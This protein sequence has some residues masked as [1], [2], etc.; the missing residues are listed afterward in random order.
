MLL[1]VV[2]RLEL[3]ICVGAKNRRRKRGVDRMIDSATDLRQAAG[4][5]RRAVVRTEEKLT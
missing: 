1:E 4:W 3:L 5:S 2:A